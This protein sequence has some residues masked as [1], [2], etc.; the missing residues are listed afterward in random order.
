MVAEAVK[1][2]K[3]RFSKNNIPLSLIEG[4]KVLDAGSG[5]GRYTC[6]LAVLGAKKVVGLDY[7][8]MGIKKGKKLAKESG[9]RNVKFIKGS[10]LDIP[11]KDEEFDFIFNNGVFHHSESIELATKELYRVLKKEGYSWYYIYGDGGLYWYARSKMNEFMKNNIPQLYSMSVLEMIGMPMNRF[12]FCDNW[13]VPIE[14]HTSADKV[15]ELFKKVGF[16][17]YRRCYS[18]RKTDFDYLI[19][20]GDEKDKQMW[21]DGDLRY[22]LK[23]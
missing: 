23:K 3:E 10:V 21:G 12:I 4:K 6:A 1:I 5:S 19:I 9:T 14:K 8:D 15:E 11:F 7:S 22:L 2:I 18:G 16:S 13:Y 17:E 20:K